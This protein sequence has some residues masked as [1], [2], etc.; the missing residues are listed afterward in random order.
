VATATNQALHMLTEEPPRLENPALQASS[1]ELQRQ[2]TQ[3]S[4]STHAR[5]SPPVL[6][7]VALT[8]G[9]A[10][11]GVTTLRSDG[12][13][14]HAV[15]LSR[16]QLVG[17]VLI[18]MVLVVF[19]AERAWPA[20]RRPMLAKGH[21][22][23]AL[24]MGFYAV[25]VVPLVV[26]IGAGFADL[27]RQLVP[28]LRLPAISS[29]PHWVVFVVAL[30]V[31]DGCNWLAHWAN[32]RWDALWRLHALHHSQPEMSILTSFRAHPLVH[33]SFLVSVIPAFMLS[34]NGVVPAT[35]IVAYLCLGTFP[36]ANLD[37]TLG[38]LGRLIVSPAY[39][40]RHHAAVGRT[41]VN[42][43][44]V[45]TIWDVLSGRAIFPEGGRIPAPTGIAGRPIALEQDASGRARGL[46][47][48]VQLCEPLFSRRPA[49]MAPQHNEA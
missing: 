28:W 44:T 29:V 40:R 18:T 15:S 46:T 30:V 42:L 6:A 7:A 37:W 1:G 22:Q 41:D 31:L 25:I 5:L 33:T 48:V 39:H 3:T 34:A 14:E 49:W 11:R 43:G 36:H 9:L 19:V 12:G 8:G 4:L 26:L 17:P 38:P 21:V 27:L 23:D 2:S 35:V 20:V 16:H 47:F 32:H 45:L 10:W 24:Y 13:V